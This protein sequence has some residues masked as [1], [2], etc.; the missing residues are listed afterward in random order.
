MS[1]HGIETRTAKA[2]ITSSVFASATERVLR[3]QKMIQKQTY[4][5]ENSMSIKQITYSCTTLVLQLMRCVRRNP[6]QAV[7]CL[8][9]VEPVYYVLYGENKGMDA[10]REERETTKWECYALVSCSGLHPLPG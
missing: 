1:E 4:I 2:T 9:V 6:N 8:F 3:E 7:T 5:D 10:L